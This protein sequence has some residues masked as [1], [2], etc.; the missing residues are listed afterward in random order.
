MFLALIQMIVV[1]LVFASVVRGLTACESLDQLKRAGLKVMVFFA[2]TTAAATSLGIGVA[3]LIR[4]GTFN[5][6]GTA[7]YQGVAAVFLAQAFD[8]TLGPSQLLLIVIT[9]VAA[10]IGS[11]ATPGVGIVIL[12]MVLKSAGI[13]ASGAVLLIGVD[14]ILDMS[15]T[16][17]NVMGDLVACVVLDRP[18][19]HSEQRLDAELPEG[20]PQW[21]AKHQGAS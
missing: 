5:M 7:L 15:R 10:S 17:A 20:D 19:T 16:A 11:P 2:T 14:R 1:P 13:P 3:Y 8:I 21:Q 18:S 12:A 6:A 9:A 4:P